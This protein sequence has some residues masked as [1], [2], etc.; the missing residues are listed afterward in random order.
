MQIW[1][2]VTDEPVTDVRKAELIGIYTT[3]PITVH[4]ENEN[5]GKTASYFGRWVTMRGLMG[6]WSLPVW[7]QSALGGG[8]QEGADAGAGGK[9]R[10]DAGLKMAA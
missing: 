10:E 7:M 9:K 8:M 6:P 4:H 5:A 2:A 1:M 3:C